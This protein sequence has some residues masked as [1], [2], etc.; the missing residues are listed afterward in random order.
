M[1]VWSGATPVLDEMGVAMI[2]D[3]MKWYYHKAIC[4]AHLQNLTFVVNFVS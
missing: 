2:M 3:T 4:E 1:K